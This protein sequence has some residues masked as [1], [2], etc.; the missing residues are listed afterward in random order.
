MEVGKALPLNRSKIN[1]KDWLK[2][3]DYNKLR[4]D[5]KFVVLVLTNAI[6]FH[7][8]INKLGGI[9]ISTFLFIVGFANTTYKLVLTKTKILL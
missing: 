9:I 7:R 5:E 3:L 1:Y 4:I 2:R 8:S 6:R